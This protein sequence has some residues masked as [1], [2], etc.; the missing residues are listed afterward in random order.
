[1]NKFIVPTYA[2]ARPRDGVQSA[3]LGQSMIVTRKP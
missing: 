1:M 2:S 3:Y